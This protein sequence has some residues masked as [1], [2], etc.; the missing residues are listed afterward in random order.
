MEAGSLAELAALG[1]LKE[2]WWIGSRNSGSLVGDHR[3]VAWK[4]LM[5][6]LLD[7]HR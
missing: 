6:A 5:Q 1:G 4:M 7:G 3:A 2:L